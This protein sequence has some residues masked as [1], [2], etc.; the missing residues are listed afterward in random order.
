MKNSALETISKDRVRLG[1]PYAHID[2]LEEASAERV[3]DPPRPNAIRRAPRLATAKI[4]K[5]EHIQRLAREVQ[6][7][8]WRHAIE[9]SDGRKPSDPISV[10][11]PERALVRLGFSVSYH[12]ALG[13]FHLGATTVDVAGLIDPRQKLVSIASHFPRRSQRYTLAHELGHAVLHDLGGVAHRDRP[14]DGSKSPSDPLEVEANRF[15][16]C[17]LMPE[18]LVRQRFKNSFVN[19]VFEVSE[20]TVFALA[21]LSLFDFNRR[22]S[23]LRDLSIQLASAEQFNGHHFV[24][25]AEQFQV[26]VLAMAIRL[27][28]LDLVVT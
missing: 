22:F 11:D 24:S 1:N 28:E 20:D 8:L 2:F 16:S 14:L 3:I 6:A 27:E 25:L 4:A 23:S 21:G 26:S 7:D 15:A 9:S 13:Q 12:E 5:I 18:R 10:L 19:G 17:F